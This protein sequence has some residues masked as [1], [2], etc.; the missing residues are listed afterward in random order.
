MMQ[1][2][3]HGEHAMLLALRAKFGQRSSLTSSPIMKLPHEGAPN[4][5]V[6]PPLRLLPQ[7]Y[8]FVISRNR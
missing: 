4:D 3:L 2:P 7:S 1:L 5:T 6:R 8:S